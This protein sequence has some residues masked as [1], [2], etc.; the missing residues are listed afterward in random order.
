MTTIL[1]VF[2]SIFLTLLAV[3]GGAMLCF[4][5]VFGSMWLIMHSSIAAWVFGISVVALLFVLAFCILM[6]VTGDIYDWIDRRW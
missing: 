5:V 4:G 3:V 1:K 6:Q 2:I